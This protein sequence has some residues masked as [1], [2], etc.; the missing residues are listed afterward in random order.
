VFSFTLNVFL[1]ECIRFTHILISCPH[2]TVLWNNLRG[3]VRVKRFLKKTF[4][5]KSK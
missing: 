4:A 2:M 3:R 1:I 5:Y